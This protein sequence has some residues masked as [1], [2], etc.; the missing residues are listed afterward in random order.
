MTHWNGQVY[1][2]IGDNGNYGHLQNNDEDWKDDTSVILR[3]DP[4]G[5][6]YAIGIR[7]SFGLAFDPATGNLWDTEN[8]PDEYDEI[9][10]VPD[11]FNSGWMKIMGPTD[12]QTRIDLLPKYKDYVYNN[13]EFSWFRTVGPTAIEFGTPE[14][15]QADKVFTL[16]CNT[17]NL[18]RF[19][20]NSQRDGFVFETPELQDLVLNID[21]PS[22][23]IIVGSGF[24]CATDIE[25]GPDGFLYILSLSQGALHRIVPAAMAE[26]E[27]PQAKNE[28]LPI[29]YVIAISVIIAASAGTAVILRGRLKRKSS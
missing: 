29:Q 17:G 21:D 6:Y 24:G 10:L 14:I 28:T 12:N 4:P 20:L 11:K 25:R 22:D 2:V 3:I 5:P 7:N 15:G 13:P 9:N 1:A 19:T 27:A 23:E 8:G 16:D 26:Q 18:Y